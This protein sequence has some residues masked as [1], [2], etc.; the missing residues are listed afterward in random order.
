MDAPD[1]KNLVV[2]FCD[3]DIVQSFSLTTDNKLVYDR[4]GH[5]VGYREFEANA[6]LALFNCEKGN[7]VVPKH[8]R[9]GAKDI[10][11]MNNSYLITKKSVA[12]EDYLCMTPMSE[13]KS[14]S[15]CLNDPIGITNCSD[16]ASRILL[17][18]EDAF[19]EDR[20][21]LRNL[22]I[23]PGDKNCDF[24]VC[25][26]N[27][28]TPPIKLLPAAQVGRCMNHWEC[29]TITVKTA[30]RPN[31]ILR[32]AQSVRDSFGY[33]LP[34]ACFDDGPGN[35]SDDTMRRIAQYPMLNYVIG[36]NDD[37]GI[38]EGRNKAM[39]MVQTK[40]FLLMD[41]DVLMLNT[42]DLRTMVDILDTTDA[43]VV[44][45]H[46]KHRSNIAGFL[47]AGY[48][49]GTKRKLGL[50]PGTC[51]KLNRTVPNYPACVQCDLNLNLFMA[52]T[53]AV[54]ATG[55]WDPE[56]K[57]LEHKEI[58]IR[59]K[60]AG[61]KL[62]LCRHIELDHVPPKRNGDEELKGDP[63]YYEKRRRSFAPYHELL[64]NRYNVQ[65]IFQGKN[66]D[67]DSEGNVLY[68]HR[69]DSGHC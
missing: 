45:G 26:I 1:G 64:P 67:I 30:R 22:G 66:Q 63:G 11:L 69:G 61:L 10:Y 12:A 27:R 56:L 44:G 18:E 60:S 14:E 6:T 59:M 15:P 46:L 8:N 5:C 33:D 39:S 28:M 51:D 54:R 35:H 65:S 38:A 7:R 23:P 13:Y 34:I 40:Y 47:K 19:Q 36:K 37:Y 9:P 24:R 3:P 48:F 62:A 21:L 52:K 57:I 17:L 29:V 53:E 31:L 42:T 16:I 55:G 25:G 41:D 2:S 32:L 49:N 50:F 68:F 58:F 20:Q 43:S 4:T